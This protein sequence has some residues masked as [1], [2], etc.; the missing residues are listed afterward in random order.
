MGNIISNMK[1]Y[2][3]GN[4]EDDTYNNQNKQETIR[5]QIEIMKQQIDD[6]DKNK[7]NIVTKDEM[8]I[9][10]DSLTTKID[11][12]SDGKVTKDEL[13]S[14][15]TD[16]LMWKQEYD[17]LL[18]KYTDLLDNP[19]FVLGNDTTSR[20]TITNIISTKALKQY[21]NDEIIESSANLKLVPDSIERKLYL[22]IYKTIM[23]S[24]KSL[25]NTTSIELMN[26]EIKMSICPIIPNI[27]NKNSKHSN[28]SKH[29]NELKNISKMSLKQ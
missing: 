2:I 13:K 16:N 20:K 24:L 19:N 27:P 9:Y 4:N 23:E 1:N 8:K 17:I 14:Y 6:L 11:K 18:E 28:D 26:H 21:I 3:I 15:V 10:F 25:C 5:H 12:N 22:P 29:S 7:D